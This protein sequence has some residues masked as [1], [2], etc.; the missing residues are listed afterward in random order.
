VAA[1]VAAQEAAMRALQ[2]P[3]RKK[4]VRT[5]QTQARAP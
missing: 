1:A 5:W 3:A 2:L 4:K